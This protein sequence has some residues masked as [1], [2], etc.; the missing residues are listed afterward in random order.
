MA[1]LLHLAIVTARL[2]PECENSNRVKHYNTIN[3]KKRKIY[4]K[5]SEL[6]NAVNYVRFRLKFKKGKT[7]CKCVREFQKVVKIGAPNVI[8]F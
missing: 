1:L 5:G 6:W 3:N 2:A 4:R 8:I 7:M